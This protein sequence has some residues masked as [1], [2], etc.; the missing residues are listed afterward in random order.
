MLAV[1]AQLDQSRD[2]LRAAVDA[3]PDS[4]R[5]R[6]PS[7]ERWSALEIVEHV[8]L[9]DARFTGMLAPKLAQ[10]REQGLGPETA[11]RVP[12]P[13]PVA[14]AL[15]DRTAPRRAPDP[16]QPTGTLDEAGAWAAAH[17]AREAFRALVTSHDGLALSRVV[18]DHA[19]FGT[20]DIYQWVELVAAHEVRHAQQVR[21]VA[22]RIGAAR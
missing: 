16:A 2:T 15:G 5:A 17:R 20:L 22:A 10:A 14:V 12:L 13:A 19:F 3:M 21:E 7:P 9:V 11:A 6:R 8:A 4:D 18:H 1:L